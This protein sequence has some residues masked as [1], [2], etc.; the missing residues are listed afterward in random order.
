M[1]SCDHHLNLVLTFIDHTEKA[2]SF[3]DYY[4]YTVMLPLRQCVLLV[5]KRDRA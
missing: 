3:V 2:V 5:A 1:M 4:K